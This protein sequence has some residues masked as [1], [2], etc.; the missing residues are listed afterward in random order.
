MTDLHMFPSFDACHV[1]S[2]GTS[3]REEAVDEKGR[4]RKP[5]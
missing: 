3:E 2:H 5:C 4:C 1:D